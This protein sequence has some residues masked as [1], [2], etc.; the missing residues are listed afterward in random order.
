M[1]KNKIKNDKKTVKFTQEINNNKKKAFSCHIN[2]ITSKTYDQSLNHINEAIRL[3]PQ[4]AKYYYTRGELNRGKLYKV[5]F[6]KYDDALSDFNK[7]MK[8]DPEIA[9]YYHSRGELYSEHYKKYDEALQD[10]NKTIELDSQNDNY[11]HTRGELYRVHFKKYDEALNDFNKAIKLDPESIECFWSRALLLYKSYHNYNK[12]LDDFAMIITLG[13][14][15]KN[16]T[17]DDLIQPEKYNELQI[18][19]DL[20]IYLDKCYYL[21]SI[22]NSNIFEKYQEAL[23]DINKAIELDSK[24]AGYYDTR[25][26]LFSDQMKKYDKALQDYTKAIELDSNG[27]GYYIARMF[28]FFQLKRFDEALTDINK[29]IE[30]NPNNGSNYL[31]RSILHSENKNFVKAFHDAKKAQRLGFD[32]SI[33]L[34]MGLSLVALLQ[35]KNNLINKSL[36]TLKKFSKVKIS[37][38]EEKQIHTVNLDF[39]LQKKI[40]AAEL[41]TAHEG[42][43]EYMAEA[44]IILFQLKKNTKI[45]KDFIS[46]SKAYQYILDNSPIKEENFG[47]NNENKILNTYYDYNNWWDVNEEKDNNILLLDAKIGILDRFLKLFIS[48]S[49]KQKE[50]YSKNEISELIDLHANIHNALFKE[51]ESKKEKAIIKARVE[52]RNKIMA[53]LSH[54]V[55]NMI[56]TIIDPLEN[57]KSAGEMKPVAI[58]NAIRGA[59]LLRG[60]VNAMNLS[61]KGSIDDFIYDIKN[62][63]YKNATSIKQL[64]IESLKYSISSMFDGKYFSKFMR[65]Y[66]PNK[67]V[68]I[69]AKNK[70][71]EISQT[72]DLNMIEIFMKEFLLKSEINIETAKDFV[73][74]NDK[75]SSLKFLILIQ[76]IVFN[77]VKY[78]SFAP[79]EE[80]LIKISFVADKEYVTIKVKN[81]F[82]QDVNVKSTGLGQEIINNFSKLLQTKPITK[83]DDNTYSVEVKFKNLWEV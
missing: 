66:F 27:S 48:T 76:E 21:R 5:D 13:Q 80:R 63:E 52:E 25:A 46:F 75:G 81:V 61:F 41:F 24:N 54:T 47:Q 6:K 79:K 71:N 49:Y 42:D 72:T 68:F 39:D 14:K 33:E 67:P 7:A 12:A 29:A 31:T 34:K 2:S 17:E 64:F 50:K 60:L 43:L 28:C 70:W 32:Y 1:D 10:F 40:Y 74:G 23:K 11:Y 58:D 57:M 69:E 44:L 77:A 45:I 55:K 15:Y 18:Y 19:L 38:G 4:N 65:N 78:S 62:T 73:I 53:N 59:N 16:I 22:I 3:D 83:M 30:I 36:I 35:V 37:K 8:L 51:F 56:S 26:R 20:K 82:K 9:L